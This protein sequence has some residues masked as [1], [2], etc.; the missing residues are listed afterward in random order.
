MTFITIRKANMWTPAYY[1]LTNVFSPPYV[2]TND[3]LNYYTTI[4]EFYIEDEICEMNIDLD[5]SDSNKSMQTSSDDNS[6]END[7]MSV[8]IN[9]NSDKEIQEKLKEI[10]YQINS[11]VNGSFT[12][13]YGDIIEFPTGQMYFYHTSCIK[14]N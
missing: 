5:L 14:I 2:T 9:V 7:K 10:Y 1:K 12:L 6:N 4:H 13:N 3:I 11:V 8:D